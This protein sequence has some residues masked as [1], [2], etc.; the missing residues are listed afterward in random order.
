MRDYLVFQLYGPIAAW[1]DIAVGEVRPSTMTPSKSAVM[2]MVAAALGLRRPDT[3]HTEVDRAEW[4]A[5][6][7]ALGEG[8]GMAVKVDAV[9]SPLTDYHT[10]QVPSSGTGR[11]RQSFATRRDELTRGSRADLNTI[12]SRREY[13]QDA[14]YAVALWARPHAPHTLAELRQ[15]LLEPCFTLYLGRKSC[16]LALPLHPEIK[17]GE[18]LE[19]VL[20]GM[21]YEDVLLQLVEASGGSRRRRIGQGFQQDLP[22][23]LWESD[24]E[25][26]LS[27]EQTVTRRDVSTSR[28]RWQFAKREEHQAYLR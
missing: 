18:T 28:R 21:R 22:L 15:A 24:A 27:P 9:G 4:E 13:R 5:S 8:Y 10:A 14:F 1:G 26:G 25:T 16:P 23:L 6:H 20:S 12:L 17:N 2:G 7:C 3:A 11:N 19:A